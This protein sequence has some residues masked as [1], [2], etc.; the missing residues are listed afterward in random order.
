MRPLHS[1]LL[2]LLAGLMLSATT[3]AAPVAAVTTAKHDIRLGFTVPGRVARVLVK[4]GDTVKTGAP[5]I[6]LEDEAG[7]AQV[8][9]YALKANSTVNIDAADA[10]LKLAEVEE[11]RVRE[12]FEKSAAGKF[13]VDRAELQSKLAR[14]RL[15]QAVETQTQAKQ[16]L[17]A[18]KI[19]H[20]AYTLKA[21][22]DGKVEEVAVSEGEPVETLKPILRLVAA[23]P[24]VIDVYVPTLD[25]LKLKPGAPAW[26]RS[27]TA[28]STDSA[29]QQGT[30]VYVAQVADARSETR[31]VR[32][33][34]PNPQHDPAGIHVTVDFS[35]P[36]AAAASI[37]P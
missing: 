30:I 35:G 26:I 22:I 32:V 16:Q 3:F 25:S 23:D 18:A 29:P 27:R 11:S 37:E 15:A 34:L 33:E 19:A 1:T 6:E 4:S 2:P 20:D 28:D 10:E 36:Q 8:E 7:R 31:L 24:L 13:E 5:L 14:L 12:A 21:R 17:A 9:M